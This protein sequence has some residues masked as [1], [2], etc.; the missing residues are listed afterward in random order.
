MRPVL[1]REQMRAFDAYAITRCAV[2][3]VVL[4][5]NAGRGAADLL[6]REL[7][8]RPERTPVLVVCGPG[9]NG[10]DGFVVARQ[11]KARGFAV[12][13][14]LCG[15]FETLPGDARTNADAWRGIGGALDE[16]T[17]AERLEAFDIAL[18]RAGCVVDALYGTGLDRELVGL[19]RAVI[20]RLN[21]AGVW[22]CALDIPSGID[23]NDGSLHGVA[24]RADLT[25]TF[26]HYKLGLLTSAASAFTGRLAVAH[27]GVPETIGSEPERSA[28]LLETTDVALR[29]S[30]RARDAHKA[31]AGRV[32]AIAGSPGKTG[33]ALLVGRG[34]LRAGAGLVTLAAGQAAANA[35]DARVL[36]EMT[37]VID[38]DDLETSLGEAL[39]VS[40]CVA[41]GPGLGLDDA[42]RRVVEYVVQSHRGA[43]VLDAD[44]LTHYA[45]RLAE[46]SRA[47]GQLILTPH[48]GE[49]GRLLGIGAREVERDRFAAV[50]R[51]VELAQATVLLKG[52][53][54][55]TGAP[56]HSSVVNASGTPAL[57]TAGSGDVLTGITSAFACALPPF[58]AAFCAAHVHGLAAEAWTARTGADRGLVAH[59]IA[60]EVPR[61]IASLRARG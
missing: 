35:L 54:T 60:D 7:A 24:V 55:L 40:D 19:P 47:P 30:R 36:E 32:L 37:R 2:P 21:G 41:M 52:P 58:E 31:S 61:V 13:A 48:P 22:T 16:V 10:G 17:A 25:V 51:A 20:E 14:V 12:S 1:S 59:E 29:F 5:E 38:G 46:L 43:L 34:A 18:S 23:A 4:M 9:N 53:Y 42:A 56:G 3:G 28:E 6:A 57:A 39:S 15:A 27:I 44:A 11:L 26:A 33:A 49:L 45:G 8:A 50:A